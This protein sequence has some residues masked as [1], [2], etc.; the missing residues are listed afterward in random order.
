MTERAASPP[1]LWLQDQWD[2]ADARASRWRMRGLV[3]AAAVWAFPSLFVWFLLVTSLTGWQGE[4]GFEGLLDGSADG[5][6]TFVLA[7]IVELAAAGGLVLTARWALVARRAAWVTGLGATLL[8]QA[9]ATA[10]VLV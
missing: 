3:L 10:V 8:A 4:H 7:M 2:A 6:A 5:L 1:P 9:L